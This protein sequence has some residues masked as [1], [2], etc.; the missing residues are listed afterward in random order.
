MASGGSASPAASATAHPA[1]CPT[2]TT[3]RPGSRS[4]RFW[5]AGREPIALGLRVLPV[6][7]VEQQPAVPVR[8]REH[9][10]FD[11]LPASTFAVRKGVRAALQVARAVHAPTRAAGVGLGGAADRGD[12]RNVSTGAVRCGTRSDA[13]AR[14]RGGV[15]GAVQPAPRTG[16]RTP[17][18]PAAANPDH[19]ETASPDGS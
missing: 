4:L 19:Q 12:E 16:S 8:P 3:R 17:V 13:G 14:R 15:G 2:T 1:L 6:G 18:A 10:Q 5:I 9:A 11:G 7:L